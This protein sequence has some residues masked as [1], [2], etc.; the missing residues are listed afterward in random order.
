MFCPSGTTDGSA[1]M[2]PLSSLSED[3]P[4]A[5]LPLVEKTAVT[6][7]AALRMATTQSF[8]SLNSRMRSSPTSFANSSGN[9]GSSTTHW[10]RIEYDQ[11]PATYK[12][13]PSGKVKPCD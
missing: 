1:Q 10:H 2:H 7:N 5:N 8:V 13:K 11:V 4:L 6:N 9:F 3:S 12:P